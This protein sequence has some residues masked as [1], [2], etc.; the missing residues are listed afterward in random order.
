M[1]RTW[2][3]LFMILAAACA[4][5]VA[6]GMARKVSQG[7]RSVAPA[8]SSVSTKPGSATEDA[9]QAKSYVVRLLSPVD[10]QFD[11]TLE[12]AYPGLGASSEFQAL[13][14]NTV[15]IANDSHQRIHGFVIKWTTQS[16][17][18]ITRVAF[19]P[20]VRSAGH[21]RLVT[22]GVVL[23]PHEVRLLSPSFAFSQRQSPS[24]LLA[25]IRANLR[26]GTETVIGS[27]LDGVIFEDRTLVGSDEFKLGDRFECERNAQHDEGY[28]MSLALRD[29][30]TDHEITARLNEHIKKGWKYR[31]GTDRESFYHVARGNEAQL[32][33]RSFKQTGRAKF[34]QAV[35]Q[36][37]RMS[38]TQ[39]R[40]LPAG[41]L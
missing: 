34:E 26:S 41:E 35:N 23:A 27:S 7:P 32:L 22:G 29:Q 8:A 39:L 1:L 19:A 5:T 24:S 40:K 17:E 31:K 25:Q 20:Y 12:S 4:V 15:L 2:F 33:L 16:E 11:S 21:E 36:L 13:R 28:S 38:R 6:A 30:L 18:G 3:N 14:Q 37:L 10:N 9:T